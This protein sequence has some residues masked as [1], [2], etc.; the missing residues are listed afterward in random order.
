MGRE[1]GM[2]L[3]NTQSTVVGVQK[4]L[5]GVLILLFVGSTWVNAKYSTLVVL[6]L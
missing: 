4:G 5:Q 2:G 3:F 1:V 6:F